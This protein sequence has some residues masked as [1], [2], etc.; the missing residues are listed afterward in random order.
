M[1][2]LCRDASIAV[3]VLTDPHG[4]VLCRLGGGEFAEKAADVALQPGA[5]WEEKEAG[6]NAIG[7]ALAEGQSISVI[8]GEHF[9][10]AH[11][12]LSC[13]AAPIFDPYGAIAG[14]LDLTNASDEPQALTMALVNRAAEQIDGPCSTPSSELRTDALPLRSLFDRQLARGQPRV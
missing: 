2:A 1:E 12:I 11:S 8:G 9:F 13:S 4:L 5:V 3:V 10:E 7:A 6:T 14:V